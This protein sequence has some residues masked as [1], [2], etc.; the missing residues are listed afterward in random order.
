[1]EDHGASAF[2]GK[3]RVDNFSGIHLMD[4]HQSLAVGNVQET[5][6]D[7]EETYGRGQITAIGAPVHHREIDRD[8]GED[9]VHIGIV[10][11][12]RPDDHGF[13]Q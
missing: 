3:P 12:G 5:L 9:V 2:D 4:A 10:A 6:V 13:R 1:M 8:L 7:R 11:R